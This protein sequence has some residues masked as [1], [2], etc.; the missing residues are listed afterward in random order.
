MKKCLL[1]SHRQEFTKK[2][3]KLSDIKGNTRNNMDAEIIKEIY[4]SATSLK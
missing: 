1:T 4:H 3:N 2:F